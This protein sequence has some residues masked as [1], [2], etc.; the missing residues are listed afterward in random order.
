MNDDLAHAAGGC[1]LVGYYSRQRRSE[2]TADRRRLCMNWQILS[3]SDT[4]L[5]TSPTARS[6]VPNR[7]SLVG[8]DKG[9]L[10]STYQRQ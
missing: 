9:I 6:P 2:S 1:E 5:L 8:S 3:F 4:R 10:Q 7:V